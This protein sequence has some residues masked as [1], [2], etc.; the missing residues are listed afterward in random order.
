MVAEELGAILGDSLA[1]E[2]L[3]YTNAGG[4]GFRYEPGRVTVTLGVGALRR[5]YPGAQSVRLVPPEGWRLGTGAERREVGHEETI[6]WELVPGGVPATCEQ[7]IAIGVGGGGLPLGTLRHVI[8]IEVRGESQFDPER[9]TLPFHNATSDFGR[10]EPR[11]DLFARTYRRGGTVLADAFFKGLYRD[12][13]FLTAETDARGSGGLCTG[14]ARYALERSLRGAAS[15]ARSL[16]AGQRAS[17]MVEVQAWHGRQLTDRALLAAA[18]QFFD[19]SP[20]AAFY[21]FRD[22]LLATGRGDV[23][24]DVGIARWEP[25]PAKWGA[26]LEHLVSIGHTIT[27]YAFRQVSD[28]MAEVSVYDPSYPDRAD[29]PENVVRFDLVNDRYFY[30]GFGSLERDD[31][32]TV[33]AVPQGNFEAPGTAYAASIANLALHPELL[34]EQWRENGALRRNVAIAGG[35]LAASVALLGRRAKQ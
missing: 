19:P 29:W 20:S 34:A 32:T 30:R 1:G 27:P 17:E 8:P 21:R 14:M 16:S 13:V 2:R 12:I 26:M 22:E 6:A 7:G 5:R 9:H 35:V 28:G 33:L 18:R 25:S 24:F 3:V 11:A 4:G 31:P 23:A 15:D 10:V